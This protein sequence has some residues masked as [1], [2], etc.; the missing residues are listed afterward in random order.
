MFNPN[1][2][3]KEEKKEGN[4]TQF[5]IEPLEP[6]FGH[7]LGVALRR[8]LLQNI[9]GAAVTS[10]KIE[11]VRHMFAT[12]PGLKEDIIEFLLNVK[13]LEV[14]LAE[15]KESAKIRISKTGPGDVTAADIEV[16][17][18]VEIAD[19]D[20]YLGS[21]ADKKSKLEMEMTVERGYGYSLAE[22]R[23]IST[24]GV[25]PIDAVFSPIKKVNYR[26]EQTRVGRETNYDKLILEITTDGT[27]DAR[28]SVEQAGRILVSYFA[29]VIEQKGEEE[30]V[31]EEVAE[32]DVPSEVAKMAVD[33]LDLP[34]RIYN[35]LR[36][37][38]IETVGQLLETPRKEL[39][40]YRNLGAKSLS[41]IQE[42]LS[43]KGIQF[44]F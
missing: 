1:F 39:M 2:K 33:E 19:K 24:V 38:G 35:S 27:V 17:D 23:P 11:G 28:E 20:H 44:D 41:I 29:Q 13:Q 15:G 8:V 37:A 43:Q 40:G 12:L 4:Y 14:K 3:I 6:G 36:N 16:T 21:L 18:G 22:E 7:T 9:E 30:V 26:I 42:N 25:I 31:T 32:S 10:V 34:T 5:V